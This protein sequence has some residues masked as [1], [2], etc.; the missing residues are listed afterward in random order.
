MSAHTMLDVTPA[1]SAG[2]HWLFDTEQPDGAAITHHGLILPSMTNRLFRFIPEGAL[3]R[4]V[5]VVEV[6]HVEWVQ[7]GLYQEPGNPLDPSELRD[8][9][10]MLA[11]LGA[12]IEAMWNGKG[13]TGSLGLTR[14]AHPS[15]LAAV[16]R[17]GTGCP[18]HPKE[19]VFCECDWYRRGRALLVTPDGSF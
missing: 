16:T 10:A 2:L 9:A 5:V 8:L 15:L 18:E 14:P 11:R 17:Y 12:N 7:R 3:G 4:P 19:S 1:L 13:T 6:A